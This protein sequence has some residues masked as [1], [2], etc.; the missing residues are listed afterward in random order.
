MVRPATT[1]EQCAQH[2]IRGTVS[3]PWAAVPSLC[4]GR[5]G[6]LIVHGRQLHVVNGSATHLC[7]VLLPRHLLCDG[8]RRRIL[9]LVEQSTAHT[10]P[11]KITP[12]LCRALLFC[13][14]GLGDLRPCTCTGAGG[15]VL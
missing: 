14:R 9:N 15:P 4:A 8:R 13:T 2:G 3:F 1:P 10:A 12:A 7:T 11:E 6:V 5:A